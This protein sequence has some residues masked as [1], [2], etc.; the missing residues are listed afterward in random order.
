MC[1]EYPR[2]IDQ[3]DGRLLSY[4]KSPRSLE[5]IVHHLLIIDK[6]DQIND[7][8]CFVELANVQKHLVRLLGIRGRGRGLTYPAILDNFI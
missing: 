3:R 7:Y 5:E 4:L 6:P 8:E 2:P 1:E